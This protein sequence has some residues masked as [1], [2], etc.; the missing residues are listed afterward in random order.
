MRHANP[1]RGIMLI[2]LTMGLSILVALA[3]VVGV[4]IARTQ[5]HLRDLRDQRAAMQQAQQVLH[6]M[7]VGKP[8]DWALEMGKTIQVAPLSQEP[9]TAGHL[10]VQIEVDRQGQTATLVGLAPINAAMRPRGAA[11]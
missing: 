1:K 10:W 9:P 4:M 8:G 6:D 3:V 11:P 5:S 7:R 2:D